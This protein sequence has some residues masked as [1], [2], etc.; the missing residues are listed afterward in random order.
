M[1]RIFGALSCDQRSLAA[2][3]VNAHLKLAEAIYSGILVLSNQ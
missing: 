3:I 2:R 1:L